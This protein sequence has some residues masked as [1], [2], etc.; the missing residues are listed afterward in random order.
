MIHKNN[1]DFKKDITPCL[2]FHLTTNPMDLRTETI[3]ENITIH[4]L[5]G[6]AVTEKQVGHISGTSTLSTYRATHTL[7]HADRRTERTLLVTLMSVNLLVGNLFRFFVFKIVTKPLALENP[8]NHLTL[9]DEVI[10]AVR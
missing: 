9:L 10:K 4:F 7:F 6:A 2:R 5:I 1:P 8:I 3:M